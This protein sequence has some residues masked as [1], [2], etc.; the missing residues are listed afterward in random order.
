MIDILFNGAYGETQLIGDFLIALCLFDELHDLLFP[1]RESRNWIGLRGL[2]FAG[3]TKVLATT[4]CEI[5]A[6][7][8]TS[9]GYRDGRDLLS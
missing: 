1:K 4:C 6:A 3:L 9:F 5:L 7:P 2:G 8:C